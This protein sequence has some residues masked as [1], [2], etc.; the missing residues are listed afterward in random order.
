MGFTNTTVW[1]DIYKYRYL[2][3]FEKELAISFRDVERNK[4]PY[5]VPLEPVCPPMLSLFKGT[6]SNRPLW[7]LSCLSAIQIEKQIV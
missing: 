6:V 4:D 1:L 7:K 5:L 3:V 2:N